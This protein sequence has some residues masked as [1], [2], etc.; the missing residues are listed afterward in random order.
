M[1]WRTMIGFIG[2]GLGYLSSDQASLLPHLELPV[3]DDTI[4]YPD[5]PARSLS[6]RNGTLLGCLGANAETNKNLEET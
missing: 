5:S 2:C 3:F 4:P 6:R 1:E